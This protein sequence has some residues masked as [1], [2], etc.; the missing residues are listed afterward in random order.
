MD[1]AL[2]LPGVDPGKIALMDISMGGELAPRVAAFE[3]RI[4]MYDWLG[5]T[6]GIAQEE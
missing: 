2:T 3:K 4:A 6:I 1:F 5:Q